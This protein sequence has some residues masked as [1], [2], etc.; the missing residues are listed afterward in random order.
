MA[1]TMQNMGQD[2]PRMGQNGSQQDPIVIVGMACR[3]P[4]EVNDA[5]SLWKL[6]E[7][8]R[9]GQ[10]DVPSTRFNIDGYYQ[11]EAGMN[12]R[13]GYFIK[14]DIREFDNEFFGIL[15][16]EATYMDPQQRKLL[17]VVFECF[18]SSGITLDQVSG[19]DTGCY[20]GN[21]G[22]DYLSMQTKDPDYLSRFSATGMGATIL[23]NRISHT[24]NM[25]GPSL[26]IDT[27]CSS[28]IF[29]LHMA[30]AAIKAGDCRAAVVA[31]ANLIQS[32]EQ[33]LGMM[34][35]GV[36]SK[37]STCHTFDDSADG[38]ARADGVG[39]LYLKRL[40]D[41]IKDN[42]PIRAVIRGTAVGSNGRTRGISAPSADAQ[43]S[44]IRKAY[45]MAGL[46]PRETAFIE[47]HG[48]G[49]RAGDPIEV[50][51]LSKVFQRTSQDPLLIGSI[52]TNV[53]HSEAVSG[54]SGIIKA[55]LALEKA[56]LPPTIG[57]KKIN[58]KI[59]TSEWGIDIVTKSREWPKS[60]VRRAGVNSFGYGG[61]NGHVI[62]EA[63][64]Q[65]TRS[66]RAFRHPSFSRADSTNSVNPSPD[67]LSSTSKSRSSSVPEIESIDSMSSIGAD[68]YERNSFLFPVSATSGKSLEARVADV[69]RAA[70]ENVNAIDLAYTLGCRR[71][72]FPQHRGYIVASRDTLIQALNLD[73]LKTLLSPP[74]HGEIPF[75]FILTGQ[76]AQWPGMGKELFEEF[77]V[78]RKS[79]QDMDAVIAKVPEPPNWTIQGTLFAPAETSQIQ[80]SACAQPVST[81]LQIAT[82]QLLASWGI[83]PTLVV[84]HSSGE[85]A[86]A[87]AAGHVTEAEAI[88]AAYYRG[89]CNGINKR[90]GAMM[91]VGMGNE[92]AEAEISKSNLR[93]QVVVACVNSP[94]SVTMSGDGPA[95][96][97]LAQDLQ[98]RGIFAR[99]LGTGGKA[100]HSHHMKAL[101]PELERLI[102]VA[103]KN[104]PPSTRLQTGATFVSTV[105]GKPK[106]EGIDPTYWRTNMES[107]VLFAQ[108]ADYIIRQGDVHLLEIGPHSALE[109][110]LKQIRSKANKNS[111]PY[112]NSLTRGKNAVECA[113]GLV[114][115]L[116]LHGYPVP[117]HTV[118]DAERQQLPKV[119]P[120]MAPYTHIYDS[121]LWNEPRVSRETRSRKYPHHELLGSYVPGGDGQTF[122]WRNVLELKNVS[123][124]EGHR[125]ED[126]V[127]FPG[128][129][130]L[131]MA[132]EAVSQAMQLKLNSSTVFEFQNV[133]L[134]SAL[135]IPPETSIELFTSIHPKRLSSFTKSSEWW[136]FEVISYGDEN[137]STNSTG[138]IRVHKEADE[139]LPKICFDAPLQPSST[140]S[141][142]GKFARAG[143]NYG[144][145]Y[146]TLQTIETDGSNSL[147]V[148]RTTAPCLRDSAKGAQYERAYAIHP[149]TMDAMLQSGMIANVA[150]SVDDLEAKVS[151]SM[152]SAM[153]RLPRSSAEDCSINATADVVGLGSVE[154]SAELQCGRQTCAQIKRVRLAPYFSQKPAEVLPRHPMLTVSWKPDIYTS[155]WTSGKLAKYIDDTRPVRPSNN[156]DIIMRVLSLVAHKNPRARILELVDA[157]TCET[158]SD[159]VVFS[160]PV[161]SFTEGYLSGEGELFGTVFDPAINTNETY[162]DHGGSRWT[163]PKTQLTTPIKDQ[164]YDIIVLPNAISADLYL[165]A[166]LPKLKSLL[167]SE[168]AFILADLP[169][170]QTYRFAE[171]GFHTLQA[172]YN[173][174]RFP[175]I[176]AQPVVNDKRDTQDLVIVKRNTAG[177][178]VQKLSSMLAA[179]LGKSA[180]IVS[181]SQVTKGNVPKDIPILSLL[182]LEKP[183][184]STFDDEE[185]SKVKIL[186][187][188]ASTL[189]WTTGGGLLRGANPEFGI[190]SGLARAIMIEQ[191]T[192]AFYTFDVDQSELGLP[193]TI[194]NLLTIFHQSSAPVQDREF[195]QENGIVH[196][197]RFAPKSDLNR[198]MRQKT[199]SESALTTLR[200][201]KHVMKIDKAG[202]FDTICFEKDEISSSHTTP[203]DP[204]SVEVLVQTVGLNARD[205]D[206]MSGNSDSR[207]FTQEYCGIVT[208]TGANCNLT[209]GDRV[210]VMAPGHFDTHE[211]VP[212]WACVKLDG[213]N[214]NIACTLPVVYAT[215]LYALHYRAHLQPQETVLIHCGASDVGMA[216]IQ[217]AQ[218]AGAE[219][220]TTASS[221]LRR[222]FLI[223]KFNLKPGNVFSSRDHLYYQGI[224]AA[225][226]RGVDV[227]L[228][229]LLGDHLHDSWRL[230]APFGRFIE[231]GR[232]ELVDTGKLDMD[233]FKRDATF[234]AIDFSSLYYQ[235]STQ[236]T[237]SKLLTQIMTLYREGVIRPIEP[238]ETFDISDLPK[239]LKR[240]SKEHRMGKVSVS[241]ENP[242]SLVK[243]LPPKHVVKLAP[244]KWYILVGCLGGLGRSISKYMVARGAR[245][246]IFMGRTGIDREKPRAQVE[247]LKAAGARIKVVRGDVRDFEDVQRAVAEAE[248]PLGGVI[249]A[250]MA[251]SEALFTQMSNQAWHTCI[252]P[253]LQGSWNLHN[254]IQGKDSEL[255]FF[256]MT[257]SVSGSIGQAAQANY[258][259]A[260]FFLDC[261]ARHRRSQGLPATA[262]G[263][264]MISDVGYLHENP[265]V[266]KVLRRSGI[267]ALDEKELL[268]IIDIALSPAADQERTA[269]SGLEEAHILTGLE[270]YD[271]GYAKM[272]GFEVPLP[273]ETDPRTSFLSTA[274]V[275]ALA[276]KGQAEEA[277]S[278]TDDDDAADGNLSPL[279]AAVANIKTRFSKLLS[280]NIEKIDVTKNLSGFGLDSMMG[281]EFRNW[282]FQSYKVDVPFLELV[283]GKSTIMSLA[284]KATGG[285]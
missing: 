88:I 157:D 65:W 152:E 247:E 132:I 244:E 231:L 236:K 85:V 110:P 40:S 109:L 203:L 234:S 123:W 70:A 67:S 170:S 25:T 71:T 39:S 200:N 248:G 84:G 235:P 60:L 9:S 177:E 241:L 155:S 133:S 218:M 56:R 74:T 198:T 253:K 147:R 271:P 105:T 23:A 205:V 119:L 195:C 263:F 75:A 176:L 12:M 30:C 103:S 28:S 160:H 165:H 201:G 259:A 117:F 166:L 270:S 66:S 283:E 92:E 162:L 80:E 208:E 48:T 274:R 45:K 173:L 199:G 76:G 134:P 100:Y 137:S 143:I 131:A 212:E 264:G 281:T 130:Y 125:L 36:L 55:I 163:L 63:A 280:M 154:I 202:Q 172:N 98:S 246:F 91:A 150:G 182:E 250:A 5:S 273:A 120:N 240:Y 127:A 50:E 118:N 16:Q 149:I 269:V 148:A 215:A 275:N 188:N 122:S 86:A 252:G 277:A 242:N 59:R 113:L 220:Y 181:L 111:L 73:N 219:I 175:L 49:T 27:A 268:Q 77:A 41:A 239:A 223:D 213:E 265:E 140:Y 192:L 276:A 32:V 180:K 42:D 101:G 266:E 18:E 3:L 37:T 227:I 47:C 197:S 225:N 135:A 194:S 272:A 1:S 206:V 251:L 232:K 139:L 104:L 224:L 81:A 249:Q 161:A 102:P 26:V 256:L 20:V 8:E 167:S 22:N 233:V 254:A 13:G 78:F 82:I 46:D 31:G 216:A 191:P 204:G 19:S 229:S 168:Y 87:F 196:V 174:A 179:A 128:A 222:Q 226:G 217:M 35:A 83:V 29:C 72:H 282:Y 186:T 24:F 34:K 69:A 278:P 17:E 108:A 258:C 144:P 183:L 90:D 15:N 33:H 230:M 52:K 14:D 115:R 238:L 96:T 124:I 261:F 285:K 107:P 79:I 190:A 61:A 245:N 145:K 93:G 121:L 2:S 189:L 211:R 21:F 57:I 4:G 38:Y 62:L 187:D 97:A 68:M 89:Y 136:N 164:S 129:A 185:M 214:P 267:T 169:G 54:L 171:N 53:G 178:V 51:A 126:T 106:S 284:E 6:L 95:I 153:F 221:A 243:V 158:L 114:G 99:K 237:W 207:A 112:S 193:E 228:N 7:D 156:K 141:W 116:F 210:V 262:I 43:V 64:D 159:D 94:V 58:P 257:S 138:S 151:V 279:D 44:V 142:Y 184:L 11:P 255:D 146:Q 209:I 260:N 10:C